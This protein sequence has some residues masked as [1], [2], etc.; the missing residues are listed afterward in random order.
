MSKLRHNAPLEC[1]GVACPGSYRNT[2]KVTKTD[3][4][5]NIKEQN[6]YSY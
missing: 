6:D 5:Y 2:G 3:H 4:F 1:L